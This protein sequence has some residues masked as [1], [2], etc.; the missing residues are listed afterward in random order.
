MTQQPERSDEAR[1]LP[2]DPWK[3]FRGVMAGTLIL[4]AVVILLA[5]PVVGAVGGG[6]TGVSL[7]YLIGLAAVLLL[8]VGAQ[9]RSWAIWVDLAVQAAAIA[10]FAV[11]PGV[12]FI[13]VLFTL[14]WVL[15][16]YMRAEVRWRQQRGLLPGQRQPPD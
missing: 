11:Y 8:L 16:A 7:T 4:E 1:P 13:G 3:S 12:G 10:G 9:G 6:L 14:V 5:L 2:P 15:I